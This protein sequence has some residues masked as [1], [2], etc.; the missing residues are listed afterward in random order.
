MR[1]LLAGLLAVLVLAATACGGAAGGD[2]PVRFLV[3]GD[4][5]ELAA[6]RALA[7]AYEKQ[8]GGDARVRLFEASDRSDLIARLSTSIAGGS[9]P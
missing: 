6:Y 9:P 7:T 5:E 8:A 1:A 4:P 3:F 2:G